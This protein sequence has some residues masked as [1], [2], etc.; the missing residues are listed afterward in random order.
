MGGAENAL[1]SAGGKKVEEEGG[2]KISDE[3]SKMI[4]LR[5]FLRFLFEQRRGGG[6][7]LV[8]KKAEGKGRGKNCF[9]DDEAPARESQNVGKKQVP[10]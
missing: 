5:G 2:S 7:G 4:S 9:N 6:K 3:F 8:K 1:L 10:H